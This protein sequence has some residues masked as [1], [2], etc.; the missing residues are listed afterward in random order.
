MYDVDADWRTWLEITRLLGELIPEANTDERRR[1][2]ADTW[3][4]IQELAFGG[5]LV[6]ESAA[7]V[8]RAVCDFAQG[9]PCAPIRRDPG[10]PRVLSADYNLNSHALPLRAQFG[11]D[12]SF[13]L[14][15]PFHW[16]A[17]RL[18]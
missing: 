12:T 13:H 2:N 15:H 5:V 8:M 16:W 14:R 18:H 4:Q 10:G 11:L 6:D 7:D 9:Y 17:S 1:H 3:A